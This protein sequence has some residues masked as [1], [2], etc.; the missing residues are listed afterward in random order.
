MSNK[1]IR[2]S[3]DLMNCPDVPATLPVPAETMIIHVEGDLLLTDKKL[4]SLLLHLSWNDL[5]EKS[6]RNKWHEI[7]MKELRRLY[8]TFAG[9]KDTD[10]L[11]PAAERLSK[12]HVKFSHRVPGKE[13]PVKVA[14]SLFHASADDTPKED[15]VFR[16]MFPG[17]LIPV[18]LQPQKFARLRMQ[19]MLRL[20]SKYSIGLYELLES[21]VNKDKPYFDATPIQLRQWLRVPRDKL[22][23]WNDFWKRALKPALEELQEKEEESGLKVVCEVIRCGERSGIKKGPTAKVEKVRFLVA[24][25][26]ERR[27]EEKK[28]LEKKHPHFNPGFHPQEYERL[29]KLFP[30]LD[31]YKAEHDW[32][33]WQAKQPESPDNGV[34]AFIGF[35]KKK[36]AQLDI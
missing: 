15:G 26:L 14:T 13:K 18:L 24:K 16:Y 2:P 3:G 30:S 29:K 7:D 9:A 35:C 31:I 34:A 10:R 19:F 27:E 25:T 4:W 33:E 28:L 6:G 11:W 12:T 21:H 8:T 5:E 1:P 20:K 23:E 36:K 32:R 22:L 17:P